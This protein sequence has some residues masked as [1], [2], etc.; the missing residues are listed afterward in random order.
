MCLIGT[1]LNEAQRP[2]KR[3][4]VN[5]TAMNLS[6]EMIMKG[7]AE[8]LSI[9]LN[10][11]LDNLQGERKVNAIRLMKYLEWSATTI[12]ELQVKNN[13]LQ[14]RVKNLSELI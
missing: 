12:D 2:N 8:S 11:N 10:E 4:R 7:F 9:Q 5:K 13:H 6:D 1:N 3:N 14:E